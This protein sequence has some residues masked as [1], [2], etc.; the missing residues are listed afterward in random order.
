MSLPYN[1]YNE[2]Y[3]DMTARSLYPFIDTASLTNGSIAIPHGAFLDILI[4]S[5]GPFTAPYY[6][7]AVDGLQGDDNEALLTVSD[8]EGQEVGAAYLDNTKD[9]CYVKQGGSIQAGVIVYD[10]ERMTRFMGEVGRGKVVFTPIQT[11]LAGGQCF[12]VKASD[13]AAIA[14]SE[15]TL[16]GEAEIVADLG[17]TFTT[18]VDG[19]GDDVLVIHLYGESTVHPNALKTI[20]GIG[21]PEGHAWFASHPDSVVRVITETGGVRVAHKRDLTYG[22]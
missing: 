7:S 15:K 8:Y 19:L 22:E 14:G 6:I 10:T 18:Y 12:A 9:M 13:I 3:R 17:A 4:Y 20:N 16:T 2:E 21:F 1:I 11:T 5:V